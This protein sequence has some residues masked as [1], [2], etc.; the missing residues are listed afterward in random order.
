[1]KRIGLFLF[2][3]ILFPLFSAQAE[4]ARFSCDVPDD[5]KTFFSQDKFSGTDILAF[6]IVDNANTT[7]YA[8]AVGSK[9]GQNTLYGFEK[10]GDNYTYWLVGRT[11]LPQGKGTFTLWTEEEWIY[12]SAS[13]G[14]SRY[15]KGP[16][17]CLNFRDEEQ[18]TEINC[19]FANEGTSSIWR[20]KY[21]QRTSED[22]NTPSFSVLT[23]ED[24]LHYLSPNGQSLGKVQGVV[25]TNLR[26]LNFSGI[27]ATVK[28]AEKKFSTAPSIPWE[29]E[30][31]GQE[32][33]FDGGQKLPVYTGPGTQYP[34]A[35][36]GKAVVSTNDWIQVFGTENGYALIQYALSSDQMR[37]GY[38][39]AAALP[40]GHTVNQL[41]LEYAPAHIVRACSMTDDPLKSGNVIGK[42][43]YQDQVTWLAAMGPYVYV[44]TKGNN[45]QRGFVKMDDVAKEFRTEQLE[46]TF[47]ND[48]YTATVWLTLQ[49]SETRADILLQAKN[50]ADLPACYV[51]LCNQTPLAP[52]DVLGKAYR[53]D[54][55]TFN[56]SFSAVIPGVDEN[57]RILSL[58]PYENGQYKL[59]ECVTF[60]LP[61]NTK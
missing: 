29:S 16:V 3:L 25:Q 10:N 28:E 27:P 37:F 26:Y 48:R 9:N 17:V 23:Y 49:G 50:E 12:Y 8:F 22:K 32:I 61:S 53:V 60:I 34:R 40:E 4:G 45:P 57:T 20:L 44:E 33:A 39:D 47:K 18:K 42:L 36:S 2:L 52:I 24:H 6:V 19:I 54:E 56:V 15:V 13:E 1:M 38:I 21:I 5:V 31:I 59:D 51:P 43:G 30:L 7:D 11:A 41:V 58:C 55:N 14:H 35:G 46:S